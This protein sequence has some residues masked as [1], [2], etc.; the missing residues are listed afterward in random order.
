[1]K[2]FIRTSLLVIFLVS[3]TLL[4]LYAEDLMVEYLEGILE[5]GQGS[6]WIEVDIGDT[7][8]QNSYL[9]L[10]DNGLAELSAG[11]ITIT[12]NQDGTFSIKNL[13]TSGREVAAWNISSLVNSK[14]ARLISPDQ[15]QGTAVMGVRGA[16]AGDEELTWVEEGEEYLEQGKE[17]IRTGDYKEAREVLQEGADYSF[18]DEE[19]EEYN[20][21]IASAYALEGKS[22]P[23]L[24][25]LT[26]MKTESSTPYYSDYVLLKGKLLIEGLAYKKALLLFDQYLKKPDRSETTQL[27]Y[28][29]SALCNQRLENRRDAISNLEAAYEINNSSEYGRAARRMMD[30]L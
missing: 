11:A 29:L 27:I 26:N 18:S 13:L 14:L 6:N 9:R 20:F 17:L 4:P 24:L 2:L 10:S 15:Q 28:F 8:P 25:M 1:M 21:Y 16:A 7:I 19:K 12:L 23:A 5:V 30:N 3:A 22:A